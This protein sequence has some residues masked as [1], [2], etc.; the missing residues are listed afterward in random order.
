MNGKLLDQLAA[1]LLLLLIYGLLV[2]DGGQRLLK[3][4]VAEGVEALQALDEPAGGIEFL[5]SLRGLALLLA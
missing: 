3:L 1:E 5:S 4:A 2:P